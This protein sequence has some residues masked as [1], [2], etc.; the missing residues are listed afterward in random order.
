MTW[1]LNLRARPTGSGILDPLAVNQVTIA[2]SG[3]VVACPDPPASQLTSDASG[4]DVLFAVHGYDVNQDQGFERLDNWRTLLQ[5]GDAY[6]FVGIVWPGDSTWLG[7]LCYP[8]EGTTANDCG[9]QL[10]KFISTNFSSA[11]TVS[12]ASHSLGARVVLRTISQLDRSITVKHIAL[13]A[14]AIDADCL[15]TE[16][17][18]AAQDAGT[19]AILASVKDDVLGKAFPVGNLLD[20]IIGKEHPYWS[21]AL[22]HKG[23]KKNIPGK[24]IGGFQIPSNWDYGHHHYIEDDPPLSPVLPLPQVVP[25]EGTLPPA[26]PG[27]QPSWSAAFVSTRFR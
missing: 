15:T 25:P 24:P 10:A 23:P 13:M 19:I 16:F 6:L 22:G 2:P 3:P 7:P 20:E 21:G 1:F 26:Q 17:A 18:N 5:L 27:W 8:G 9:D 14:G 4:R 12:F 11:N